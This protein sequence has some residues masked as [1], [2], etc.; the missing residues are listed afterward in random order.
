GILAIA[1]AHL[2]PGHLASLET[3]ATAIRQDLDMA[4]AFP[5]LAAKAW[6]LRL[7]E[8]FKS[9]TCHAGQFESSIV[10]AERPDLV[11]ES[12]MASL[13]P[14]PASLS[15]AIRDGKK[16]FEESDGPLAYFGTPALATAQEGRAT[17]DVLGVILDEAVE[18]ELASRHAR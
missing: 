12:T 14:N 17:I 13:A 2:D 7:T 6:A 10:L 5:N 4:V 1:N 16:S 18:T 15:R 8:E 11:R 9:G 3:A